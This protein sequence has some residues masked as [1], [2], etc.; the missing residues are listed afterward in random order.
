MS[1][2]PLFGCAFFTY[3]VS[4]LVPL[5]FH[6]VDVSLNYTSISSRPNDLGSGSVRRRAPGG[7][8][9][10]TRRR[11]AAPC[12]FRKDKPNILFSA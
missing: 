2:P 1:L 9:K 7:D 8:S 11:V 3:G 10:H 6:T 4:Y 5:L 12:K